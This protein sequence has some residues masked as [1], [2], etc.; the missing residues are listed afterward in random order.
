MIFLHLGWKNFAAT[1]EYYPG[2]DSQLYP[3]GKYRYRC[4]V[5]KSK[6]AMEQNIRNHL[7]HITNVETLDA[8]QQQ[9]AQSSHQAQVQQGALPHDWN[10]DPME[11]QMDIDVEYEQH[12]M[13]ELLREPQERQYVILDSNN[14][15]GFGFGNEQT[16]FREEDLQQMSQWMDDAFAAGM[17][18]GALNLPGDGQAE[19]ESERDLSH[20]NW[21][22]FPEKEYFIATLMLGHLHNLLSRT[23]LQDIVGYE[24]A[25]PYVVTHMEFYPHDTNRKKIHALYHGAKWCLQLKCAVPKFMR[26]S[27][28]TQSTSSD[29]NQPTIEF[30]FYIR[31]NI[32][33]KSSDLLDIPVDDFDKIYSEIR[34]HDGSLMMEKCGHVIKELGASSSSDPILVPNPWRIKAQQRIIRHVP[35]TLYADDTSGNKSKQWNKHISFYFT[36]SGLPPEMTDMEYN[37]HFLTTS[38]VATPLKLAEPVVS[39]LN[40]LATEGSFAFDASLKQEVMYMCI[41][42]AFLA[43]SPMAAEFTNTPNPGKANN[44][45]RMCHKVGTNC[46]SIT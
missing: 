24:L 1:G 40:H 3:D 4:V 43:G 38:N 28:Q 35:L 12:Q 22:P 26:A 19:P 9:V 15:D 39:Q 44:P 25:N 34:R 37:C 27:N 8:F 6:W 36:L 31:S 13:N 30:D 17:H 23:I 7:T 14:T 2:F 21:Y 20:S 29:Q 46:Q 32:A 11:A 16:N 41:P 33:Y 45:C 10:H 18:E 5:C 42:L